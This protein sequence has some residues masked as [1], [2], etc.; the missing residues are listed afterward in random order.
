M[1]KIKWVSDNEDKQVTICNISFGPYMMYLL[2][3]V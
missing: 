2:T 1:E 3:E